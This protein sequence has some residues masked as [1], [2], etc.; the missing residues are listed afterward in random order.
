[1]CIRSSTGAGKP[2]DRIHS[3]RLHKCKVDSVA[4][5]NTAGSPSRADGPSW[6]GR[7][8]T[9]GTCLTPCRPTTSH[10]HFTQSCFMIP[11]CEEGFTT[12][13]NFVL[14]EWGWRTLNV[15]SAAE[16]WLYLRHCRTPQHPIGWS[17]TL[18]LG[19]DPATRSQHNFHGTFSEELPYEHRSTITTRLYDIGINRDAV[20]T[21]GSGCATFFEPQRSFFFCSTAVGPP[22]AAP[23]PIICRTAQHHPHLQSPG[24]THRTERKFAIICTSDKKSIRELLCGR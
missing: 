15:P 5:V 18:P 20:R 16:I 17:Q 2:N 23:P 19:P 4:L 21:N 3:C 24:V 9:V 11:Q 1:M 8:A 10:Q 7:G 13:L 22:H 14:N 12:Y 6:L